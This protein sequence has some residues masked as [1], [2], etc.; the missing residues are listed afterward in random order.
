[1]IQLLPLLQKILHKKMRSIVLI[2]H[3]AC[4]KTTLGAQLAET[5]KMRFVDID[6]LIEKKAHKS[7][8]EIFRTEGE[9]RFRELEEEV[10]LGAVHRGCVV[11]A[12]GG[13]PLNLKLMNH[14][15]GDAFVVFINVSEEE[16]LRRR[17]HDKR[18]LLY[19]AKNVFEELHLSYL[20]RNTV[21]KHHANLIVEGSN[22]NILSEIITFF[23]K[24]SLST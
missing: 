2:G 17:F 7:V 12:G 8:E 6:S 23:Q 24:T 16:L 22:E 21:Y 11:A 18:P 14:L 5:L 13:T 1:M 3:R 4:G 10:V 20:V 19:G 15:K 9:I